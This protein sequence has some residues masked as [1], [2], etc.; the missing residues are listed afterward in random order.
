MLV[1]LLA[2]STVLTGLPVSAPLGTCISSVFNKCYKPPSSKSLHLSTPAA[3]GVGE[4]VGSIPQE[5][6]WVTTSLSQ[7]ATGQEHP[8]RVRSF[9]LTSLH[10]LV[11]RVFWPEG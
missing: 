9:L 6:E 8:R 11:P 10:P 1:L 5:Q 7:P 4:H 2:D 3:P